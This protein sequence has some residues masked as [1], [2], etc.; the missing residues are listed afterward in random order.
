M[1]GLVHSVFHVLN[2]VLNL[3]NEGLDTNV[4]GVNGGDGGIDIVEIPY[5]IY[6]FW[7]VLNISEVG[8]GGTGSVTIRV[9][10]VGGA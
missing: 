1:A 2:D 3:V 7:I 8:F 10:G 4:I 6:Q 5:V 9:S